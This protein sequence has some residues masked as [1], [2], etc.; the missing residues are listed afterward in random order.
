M[1]F[2]EWLESLS[3]KELLEA[4]EKKYNYVDNTKGFLGRWEFISDKN[5]KYA[6]MGSKISKDVFHVMFVY[7]D[8]DGNTMSSL[9]NL[10]D[11][12][13]AILGSVLNVIEVELIKKY[14][15]KELRFE[16]EGEKR[17][18]MYD[19]VIR[20]YVVPKMKKYG[21]ELHTEDKED[22]PMKIYRFVT[23]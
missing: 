7:V 16:A 5:N 8:K 1:N 22:L 15:P 19:T 18:R 2:E 9:T 13:T 4:L 6:V 23:E 14:K 21:Y 20:R 17:Q 3:D 10:R 12:P 11:N